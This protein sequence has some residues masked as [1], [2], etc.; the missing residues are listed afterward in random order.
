ML[1]EIKVPTSYELSDISR[2]R[3]ILSSFNLPESSFVHRSLPI[4][5]SAC[6]DLWKQ[7][8]SEDKKVSKYY[9]VFDFAYTCSNVY[10]V[11]IQRVD[12]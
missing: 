10:L 1:V 3:T 9:L 5:I 12:G 4:A 11:G 2:L 8:Y 7:A 6:Y